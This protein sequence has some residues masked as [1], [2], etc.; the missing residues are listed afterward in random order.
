MLVEM[1]IDESGVTHLILNCNHCRITTA[2][3]LKRSPPKR[4]MKSVFYL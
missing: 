1:G 4:G 3:P 2:I